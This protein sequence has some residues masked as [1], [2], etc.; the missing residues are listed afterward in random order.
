MRRFLSILILSLASG[1]GVQA[2]APAGIVPPNAPQSVFV[3]EPG[4]GRDPFFP[5]SRRLERVAPVEAV[6][7]ASVPDCIMCKGVSRS[8]GR[9]LA[10]I[11]NYTLA[12]GE[13]FSLRCGGQS[14]KV[15]LVQIKDRAV[16]VEVN[17]VTKELPLRAGF[18]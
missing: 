1:G 4:F 3:H 12:E 18:Q 6:P 7:S 13:E 17:N 8:G 10:I 14:T 11:N 16:I 2:A 9:L 15:K 5:N